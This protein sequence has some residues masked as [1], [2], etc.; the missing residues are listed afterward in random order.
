MIAEEQL[1]IEDCKLK[2]VCVPIIFGSS[3]F[4]FQFSIFN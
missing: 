3:I 4:N 1:Q 2:I